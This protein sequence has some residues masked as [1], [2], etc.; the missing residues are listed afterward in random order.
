M[1]LLVLFMMLFLAGFLLCFLSFRLL[2]VWSWKS[3]VIR[4]YLLEYSTMESS[5]TT[6]LCVWYSAS[7]EAV[8]TF[9]LLSPLDSWP[10]T[11]GP[12]ASTMALFLLS[13]S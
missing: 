4:R 8:S 7:T 6:L 2:V 3:G 9:F 13:T 1:V 10:G 5:G 12:I 11:F